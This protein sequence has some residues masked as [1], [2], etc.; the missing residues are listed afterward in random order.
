MNELAKN[1]PVAILYAP[2]ST[3]LD[4]KQLRLLNKPGKA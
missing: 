1:Q 2:I 4:L 3:C